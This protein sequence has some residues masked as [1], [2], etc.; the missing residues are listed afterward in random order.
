MWWASS[1]RAIQ[2]CTNKDH[3]SVKKYRIFHL[4]DSWQ[5]LVVHP[6]RH[7][8]THTLSPDIQVSKPWLWALGFQNP[9]PK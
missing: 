6:S 9:N 5:V 8:F 2:L 7:L 4:E 1:P 3:K